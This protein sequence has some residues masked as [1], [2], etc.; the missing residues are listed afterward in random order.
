MDLRRA[1]FEIISRELKPFLEHAIKHHPATVDIR[2]TQGKAATVRDYMRRMIIASKRDG[3]GQ[4]TGEYIKKLKPRIRVYYSSS[5]ITLSPINQKYRIPTYWDQY[6]FPFKLFMENDGR[7]TTL[8]VNPSEAEIVTMASLLSRG[9]LESPIELRT[10][11][12]RKEIEDSLAVAK[13]EGLHVFKFG[14]N[15]MLWPPRKEVQNG[16]D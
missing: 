3:L 1:S 10:K 4:Y 15:M 9:I 11:L 8:A 16:N 7:W 13:I 12:T 14:R 5:G 2:I 6:K